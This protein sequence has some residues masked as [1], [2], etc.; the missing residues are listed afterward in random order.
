MGQKEYKIVSKTAMEH[1]K[2]G[3]IIT[4]ITRK[5]TLDNVSYWIDCLKKASGE[6]PKVLLV[7]KVDMLAVGAVDFDLDRA[8]ADASRL[9]KSLQIFPLSARTGE[10]F[11]AWCDWLADHLHA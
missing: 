4:D 3:L 7:N 9:N 2:G 5:E 1:V 10:G 11:G 8:C 6:V